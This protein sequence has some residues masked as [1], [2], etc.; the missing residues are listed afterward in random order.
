MS[1]SLCRCP[2]RGS[3]QA[4]ASPRPNPA[5]PR[6]QFKCLRGRKSV[7]TVPKSQPTQPPYKH[8]YV[9]SQGDPQHSCQALKVKPQ[10]QQKHKGNKTS[11]GPSVLIKEA[12]IKAQ[13]LQQ[14]ARATHVPMHVDPHTCV[15]TATHSYMHTHAS[16]PTLTHPCAHMHTHKTHVH[17][18]TE[19]PAHP[20]TSSP[21]IQPAQP[22]TLADTDPASWKLDL[23]DRWPRTS[24]A[25]GILG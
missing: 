17:A 22:F 10:R 20:H 14:E 19:M 2:C 9:H 12:S 18:L 15:H 23:A 5:S 25:L 6:T 16:A 7:K 21:L 3:G 8:F 4:P 11:L 13:C 24:Q 1:A